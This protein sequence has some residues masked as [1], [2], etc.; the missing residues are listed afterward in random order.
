MVESRDYR[1]ISADS[2][3]T[4]PGD[5]WTSRVDARFRDR[6]PRI[7]SFEQGDA[8]VME[9][10]P[11]PVSFGFCACA[12]LP[13]EEWTDWIRFEEM[14]RGGH[15]P[16]ARCAE[17]DQDNVDAEVVFPGRP[18]QAVVAN[19]DAGLHHAMVQ[20]YNDWLSEYCNYAPDRLGGALMLPNRGVREAVDELHRA[21]DLGGFRTALLS[22]YPHGDT[23]I[24]PEDDLLWAALEEA[25]VPIAIHILLS[26]EMPYQLDAS[27]LP[28]T[29][30]FYD[31]PGRIIELIFSGIFDRF[32]GLHFAMT[33]TDCGW[34]PYFL[35]Q[36]DDNYMRHRRATLKD[37]QLQRLPSEY[38]AD[39]F[40]FTF[41]NDNYAL[42]NRYR[43]GVERMLW[44]NDYPHIVSD[45]P[46]SWK[47]IKSSMDGIPKNE[48]NAML[49]GNAQRIY[50]FGS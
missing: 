23:A 31:A 10:V 9:G 14:R 6:V 7:Q 40:S 3:L 49:A 21:L 50:G 30:H 22:C 19:P 39:H 45:W 28:G 42:A 36:A 25:G 26:D 15:D 48:Q 4:E 41:V 18:H 34:L 20:A 29:V 33:E 2:H 1:L 17:L 32:P 37:R 12:G 35:E 8:W 13:A 38:V 27:G 11:G 46:H 47:T 24:K 16:A 43:I 44:S 5:L